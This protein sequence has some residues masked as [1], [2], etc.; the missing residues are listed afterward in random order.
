[1]SGSYKSKQSLIYFQDQ[2]SD[3]IR[4]LER[5]QSEV[6]ALAFN[7]SGSRSFHEGDDVTAEDEPME[8]EDRA[9]SITTESQVII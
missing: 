2:H 9:L 3:S 5:L 8:D 1:M 4:Q 7:K 6:S